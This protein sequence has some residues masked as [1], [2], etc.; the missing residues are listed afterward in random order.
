MTCEHTE[1]WAEDGTPGPRLFCGVC[2]AVLLEP[3]A[4]KP[5]EPAQVTWLRRELK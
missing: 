4:W 1:T 3:E 5:A 2:G